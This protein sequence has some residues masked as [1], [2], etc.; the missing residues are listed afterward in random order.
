M[1]KTYYEFNHGFS[2]LADVCVR[3]EWYRARR[4]RPRSTL[5]PERPVAMPQDDQHGFVGCPSTFPFQLYAMGNMFPHAG[6]SNFDPS[7]AP[8]TLLLLFVPRL[9]MGDARR[10]CA[11][12][13][14]HRPLGTVVV[15]LDSWDRR[16]KAHVPLPLHSEPVQD[17][18]A[19]PNNNWC[20]HNK[21]CIQHPQHICWRLSH[22]FSFNRKCVSVKRRIRQ[23]VVTVNNQLLPP[24]YTLTLGSALYPTL[25]Y[26]KGGNTI[27]VYI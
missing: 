2:Q 6:I 12:L 16:G 11:H 18:T 22:T 24:H 17:V 1:F 10:E 25:G 5:R 14:A 9:T 15:F 19:H 13:S 4:R 7:A 27:C 21:S 20:E 26:T 23:F 3:A 8:E